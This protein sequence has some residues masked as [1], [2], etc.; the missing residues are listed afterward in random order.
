[1][2][3]K[4]V[5]YSIK[6]MNDVKLNEKCSQHIIFRI[7]NEN[8]FIQKKKTSP[9]MLRRWFIRVKHRYVVNL[10]CIYHI[11]KKKRYIRF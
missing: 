8:K 11:G 9:L 10:C 5:V 2:T 7:K 4:S 6:C 1:M 3:T